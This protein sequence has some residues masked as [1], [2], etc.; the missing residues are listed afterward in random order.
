M[1]G[2]EQPG[3]GYDGPAVLTELS[4]TGPAPETVVHVQLRG[5]FQPVNGRYHWY[6][7]VRAVAGVLPAP[8]EL[9]TLRTPHGAATGQLSDL[10]LWGRARIA[11]W[12]TPPFPVPAEPA[13]LEPSREQR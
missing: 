1:T 6:G 4:G 8:G 13:E 12:S 7:R 3:D 11:G 10:D 5:V 9:V 2:A